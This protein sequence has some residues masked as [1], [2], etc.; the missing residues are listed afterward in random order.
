MGKKIKKGDKLRWWILA[1]AILL[2]CITVGLLVV[3]QPDRVSSPAGRVLSQ[4]EVSSSREFSAVVSEE[5]SQLL[6][7][8]PQ[9]SAV[10]ELE[11]TVEE[12]ESSPPAGRECRGWNR[13]VDLEFSDCVS[14]A[15]AAY[16]L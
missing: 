14:D 6:V 16:R 12:P 13:R 3:F 2:L 9:S 5:A 11:S 10:S 15:P 7:V 4:G 1:A 8:P